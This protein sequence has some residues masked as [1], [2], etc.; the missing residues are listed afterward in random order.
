MGPHSM[1]L[2]GRRAGV[3]CCSTQTDTALAP[4]RAAVSQ[5]S[6]IAILEMHNHP[7]ISLLSHSAPVSTGG[8]HL[9]QCARHHERCCQAHV[10]NP[11]P[12]C[13]RHQRLWQRRRP[14]H[15]CFCGSGDG[16]PWRSRLA[17]PQ[18]GG[19]REGLGRWAGVPINSADLPFF[20][21]QR[22]PHDPALGSGAAWLVAAAAC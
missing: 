11:G 20:S 22:L 5:P 12:L 16:L 17:V 6:L 4:C 9:L 8:A 19:R 10:G 18:G 1:A 21:L 14:R 3:W 13:G 7:F 15:H 2:G